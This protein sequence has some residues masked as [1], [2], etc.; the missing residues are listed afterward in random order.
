MQDT[1]RPLLQ[2]WFMDNV[3]AENLL[4]NK[5]ASEQIMWV[6]DRL[7]IVFAERFCDMNH[8][9]AIKILTVGGTHHSKS[10]LLP[11]YQFDADGH[12]FKIRANFYDWCV[13]YNRL[14][15]RPFPKWMGIDVE[16]NPKAD[17]CFE[18]MVNPDG[19]KTAFSVGS[20]ERLY[21]AIQ[22]MVN[23]GLE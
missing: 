10:V 12:S 17:N 21:A 22:W 2:D 11:V 23:E 1:E 20:R 4:W 3:P 15:H 9:E 5:P 16:E 18:G 14:M 7:F 13:R 8:D 6:R 19:Y